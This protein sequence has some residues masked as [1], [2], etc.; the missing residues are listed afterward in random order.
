MADRITALLTAVTHARQG[1]HR[2]AEAILQDV[3]AQDPGEPHALFLLG[4][5]AMATGRAAEAV[6]PFE[7]A[8]AARPSHRDCRLALARALLT[9]GRA[10]D[11]LNTLVPVAAD[12]ALAPAQVLRGTA[13]NALGRPAEAITAFTQ[14]LS[15]NPADAE[16]AL[17]LGNAYA[18][19]DQLAEAERQ[20]RRAI[21]LDPALAAAH[22]SL[23]FVLAAQGAVD[24]AIQANDAALRLQ[25][26]FAAAHWNQGVAYLLGGHFRAGWEK[27]EW[28]KRHFPAF[29]TGLPGPQWD[30]GALDGKTILILAEQGFGDTIQFARY[31]PLLAR[32][33][34]QVVIECRPSIASLLAALPG[35]SA[36][37][38]RGQR[39]AYDVWADQMSLPRLFGTTIQSIPYPG[40]YL[41]A[42]P[43]RAAI[44]DRALPEGPRVGLA[45]AGNPLHSND[46][47]RSIPAEILAPVVT[48]GRRS[49]ITLQTD[50]QAGDMAK[51]FGL[52]DRSTQLVD[53]AD[54][55]AA[56]SA[57]DLVITVDT[58][59]A[60][61]AG[62][63]GIPCWVMLPHAP[64]W[65]WMLGRDDSP[66]Y[67]GMRLFRQERPGD[68][69]GVAGRIAEALKGQGRPNEIPNYTMDMPPLTW[70]V[71][72]V[73]QLAS[74]EAK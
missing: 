42:D 6:A 65:R 9:V 37:V 33:G 73:T 62:A 41:R 13:L 51:A 55:A 53:W 49:L 19:L 46:R 39:H 20:I 48:A 36:V 15:V 34:A 58:A 16:A 45:W 66:W 30:G 31:L 40:G 17:N 54:T 7:T 26:D 4:Q 38:P 11:C 21:A 18:D 68:W 52:P 29:F 1:E 64:D 63:L 59:I 22:T 67:A 32:R 50:P 71:A 5:C 72:P 10:Q 44:W 8:L 35:V 25:P 2:E 23:G 24:A 56:I 69:A 14:A 47:R 27:Y 60:H 28:R 12:A 61:L 57:M 43:E 74:A 3:L 70:S